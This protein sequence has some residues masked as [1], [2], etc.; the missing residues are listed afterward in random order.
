VYQHFLKEAGSEVDN[1]WLI[2]GNPFDVVGAMS[3][4]LKGAWVQR[5]PQAVF[6]PC[7][8]E[9]DLIVGSLGDLVGALGSR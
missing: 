3:A 6:D 8:M 2:S 4:G 1:T 7:D 5:T 9:P